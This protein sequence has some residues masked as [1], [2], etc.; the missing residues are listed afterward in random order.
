MMQVEALGRAHGRKAG[1]R[2]Q[3][4]PQ[5]LVGV[6]AEPGQG[7]MPGAPLGSAERPVHVVGATDVPHGT[8]VEPSHK[9][10]L[11]TGNEED[12]SNKQQKPF[13]YLRQLINFNHET[14]TAYLAD[15]ESAHQTAIFCSTPNAI[16][17]KSK[18]IGLPPVRAPGGMMHRAPFIKPTLPSLSVRE[19]WA[20]FALR[21]GDYLSS[22]GLRNLSILEKI[23]GCTNYRTD[24]VQV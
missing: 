6:P 22:S 23:D 11:P 20:A 5:D 14:S 8:A 7:Q 12:L 9:Q 16:I 4:K 17:A 1:A 13:N 18:P 10:A 15:A 19:Q 21:T 24:P 2:D 3:N